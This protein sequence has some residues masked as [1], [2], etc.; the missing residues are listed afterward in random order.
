MNKTKRASHGK[1]PEKVRYVKGKLVLESDYIAERRA[2]ALARRN[3]FMLRDRKA[4][5]EFM[6]ISPIKHDK[7]V[8][9]KGPNIK[10]V[11]LLSKFA[12]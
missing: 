1:E 8:E 10:M 4:I 5:R 2:R 6:E 11:N 3:R 7:P 9:I 12:K